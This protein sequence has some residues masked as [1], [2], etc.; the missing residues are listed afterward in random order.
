MGNYS[1]MSSTDASAPVETE[2]PAASALNLSAV[3]DESWK[4]GFAEDTPMLPVIWGWTMIAVLLA[5]Q[6]VMVNEYA[7]NSTDL[8]MGD[9]PVWV[10]YLIIQLVCLAY[11]W[12]TVNY[13]FPAKP[14][15]FG[16][17]FFLPGFAPAFLMCAFP[18]I[19]TDLGSEM[20][21]NT[22]YWVLAL[23]STVRLMFESTVQLHA[24]NGVK[25]I[26]YWL[27]WPIQKAPESYTMT[28]PF[29]NWKVT[30]TNGANVD[31]FSSLVV[32]VPTA[33]ICAIVND[34]SN[35]GI[36]AFCWVAQIWMFVYL[37]ALGPVPHFLCGMPGPNNIFDGKGDPKEHTEMYGLQR[38]TL[39][40]CCYWIASYAVIHFIVFFRR[41]LELWDDN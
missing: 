4:V 38:G 3:D 41:A 27:L 16:I 6:C 32:G 12:V 9:A 31:A 21:K 36:K 15:I 23:W 29:I 2:L 37:V 24:A 39:G 5:I 28:Y 26:S 35:D 18:F 7:G 11:S 1:A 8:K 25:G 10:T 13:A 34:D 33:I 19:V 22:P 20:A 17:P 40:V 30:R 14:T